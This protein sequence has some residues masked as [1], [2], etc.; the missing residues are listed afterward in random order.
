MVAAISE[1]VQKSNINMQRFNASSTEEGTGLF[2]IA[3][4]VRDRIQLVELMASLR[5]VRGVITVERIRGSAFGK[6]R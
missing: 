5:R 2:Q 3:L 6:V 1:A 4:R